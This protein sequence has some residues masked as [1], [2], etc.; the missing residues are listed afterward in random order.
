MRMRT[1]TA[2]RSGVGGDAAGGLDAVEAGHLDVH[3]HDVRLHAA[4]EPHGRGAV[5]GVADD[6]HVVLGVEQGPEPGPHQRL[7]VGE[8]DPDHAVGTAAARA[9]RQEFKAAVGCVRA[10]RMDG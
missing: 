3:Q 10:A 8:Q 4:R 2:A 7:V 9:G 6:L 5:R 1:R